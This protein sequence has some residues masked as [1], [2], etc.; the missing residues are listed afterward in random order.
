M[1]SE[2]H[3]FYS[4]KDEFEIS[5]TI[6]NQI[7][8]KIISKPNVSTVNPPKLKVRPKSPKLNDSNM[9]LLC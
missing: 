2:N 4:W 9:Y 6:F 3:S 5:F 1:E 8:I 7:I